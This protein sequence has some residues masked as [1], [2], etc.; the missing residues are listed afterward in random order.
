MRNVA[1]LATGTAIAQAITV[2]ATPILSR[3]YDPTAFGVL[4]VIISLSAPL[5]VVASGKYELAILLPKED[6]DAANIFV[7]CC[8]VVLIMTGL[9]ALIAYFLGLW[10]AV[11]MGNAEAAPLMLLLPFIFWVGGIYGVA[12]HWATRRQ[13]FSRQATAQV[14]RSSVIVLAQIVGGLLKA[15]GT[16][17]VLG[18]LG[19][20]IGGLLL[21]VGQLWRVDGAFILRSATWKRIR[22]MAAEHSVF[23]KY[24]MPR[25]GLR[26]LSNNMVPILLA[27]FFNSEAAGLF[28]FTYRLLHMPT[29]FI[30][31]AV[32]RVFYQRAIVLYNENKD[33]LSFWKKTT[34]TMVAIGLV[35]T[36]AV[37]L[38]GPPLFEIVFG[39]SWQKAGVYAQWIV[40]FWY[41][42]FCNIPCA[43]LIPIFR[44]QPFFLVYEI[45]AA[46]LRA[47]MIVLGSFLGTDVTAVALYSMLGVF[48][49]FF[50]EFYVHY[51]VRRKRLRA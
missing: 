12:E 44:L 24:N 41:L 7:L 14:V 5:G 36:L 17:L 15:G 47:L 38:F 23:P 18:R 45:V 40:V 6:E 49:S 35:P 37:V 31:H 22:R 10:I 48:L 2:A 46:S 1:V 33:V 25:A 39:P 16:G 28:W 21:L 27:F 29:V 26:A 4:A 34:I 32:E 3:L 43:T 20:S 30:G 19:G 42:T 50:F 13:A 8:L 51:L 11:K 9:T